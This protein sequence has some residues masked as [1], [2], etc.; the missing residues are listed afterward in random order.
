MAARW[1]TF[2]TAG[3][4]RFIDFLVK[5]ADKIAIIEVKYKLPSKAGAALTRLI[6]QMNS[7]L[8]YAAANR[9]TQVV[10]Y[11]FKAPTISEMNRVINALGTNASQVQFAHG[12]NGLLSWIKFYFR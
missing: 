1:G 12:L 7:S 5:A 2:S 8:S 3:G 4:R 11:T 6:G 9:G 10:L